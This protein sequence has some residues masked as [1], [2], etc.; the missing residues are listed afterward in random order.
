MHMSVRKLTMAGLLGGLSIA[1]GMI[2]GLGFIPAPTPAGSITIMHLPTVLGGIVGGPGVGAVVGSIFGVMSFLRAGSPMFADPLVAILPRILIGVA[3][4]YA[5]RWLSRFGQ[6]PA[7]AGAGL[8]GT[9]TN[10]TLV[11]G[12]GVLRGYLNALAAWTT[13]IVSAPLEA[14]FAVVAVVAVGLALGRAG[15]IPRVRST[16]THSSAA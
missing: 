5:Y 3:A 7:L 16:T 6:T 2:P 10:T 14:A 4:G 1:M 11:L 15:F 8:V 9:L 13:A 12:M